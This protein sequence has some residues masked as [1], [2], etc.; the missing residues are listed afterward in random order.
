MGF[1]GFVY[2]EFEHE[3]VILERDALDFLRPIFRLMMAF[4]DYTIENMAAGEVI[5]FVAT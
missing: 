3:R 2:H 4:T 1:D 5:V